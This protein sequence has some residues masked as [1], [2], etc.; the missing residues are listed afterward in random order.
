MGV[1]DV[2]T[3]GIKINLSFRIKEDYHYITKI[4]CVNTNSPFY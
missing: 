2:S 1:S 3:S 4:K